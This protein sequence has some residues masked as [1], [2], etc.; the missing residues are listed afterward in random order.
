MDISLH[1][2]LNK[3]LNKNQSMKVIQ[4]TFMR[5]SFQGKMQQ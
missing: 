5:R 2:M 3:Q 1:H 4:S